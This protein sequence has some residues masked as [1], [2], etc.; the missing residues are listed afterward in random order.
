MCPCWVESG[1]WRERVDKVLVVDCEE[2]TRSNQPAPGLDGR[3][4][5]RRDGLRKASRAARAPPPTR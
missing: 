1:R 5:T 4:R 3:A 2:A